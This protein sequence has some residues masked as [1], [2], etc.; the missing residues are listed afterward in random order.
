VEIS[1]LSPL[2]DRSRH[3]RFVE[4]AAG[5]IRVGQVTAMED[6]FPQAGTSH[7][8]PDEGSAEQAVGAD[9]E[10]G[11]IGPFKAAV[12]QD[13]AVQLGSPEIG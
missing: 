12:D 1:S 9:P 3:H 13:G 6:G 7:A 11:Q 8:R 2:Q 5:H 4:I 10:R